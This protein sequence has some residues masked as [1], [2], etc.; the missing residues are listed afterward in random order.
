[1]PVVQA[2]PQLGDAH[3]SK[4]SQ[5]VNTTVQIIATFIKFA[6]TYSPSHSH[7]IKGMTISY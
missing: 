7:L 4:M 3:T 5:G 6:M 2:L 1:M